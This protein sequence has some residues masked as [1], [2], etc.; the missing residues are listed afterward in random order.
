IRRD[1]AGDDQMNAGARGR[2]QAALQKIRAANGTNFAEV[3]AQLSED[4]NSAKQ[5]GKLPAPLR[6]DNQPFGRDF[7]AL[8]AAP[9]GLVNRVLESAA[10]FHV[11]WV[12]KQIPARVV[13]L[14]EVRE[15]L[16]LLLY[17]QKSQARLAALW[18]TLRRDAAIERKL[19]Y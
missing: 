6:R 13:P 12:E 7:D 5:G 16:R 8:F 4:R 9:P 2:A 3:A 19:K 11:V 10:G 17:D 14:A 15:Q 18:D 1:P